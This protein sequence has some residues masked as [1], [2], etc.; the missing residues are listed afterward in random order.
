M[1]R[2]I[3]FLALFLGPFLV[4]L[5]PGAVS[6]QE[7]RVAY[8]TVTHRSEG[9]P[10]LVEIRLEPP[11]GGRE[12]AFEME[13]G[14]PRG[15]EGSW[16]RRRLHPVE[17][18]L[19]RLDYRFLEEGPW[20]FYVHYGSGLSGFQAGARLEVR[21][22]PGGVDRSS[23]AFRLFPEGVAQLPAYVQPLGYSG[24][25]LLVAV[26]LVAVGRILGRLKRQLAEAYPL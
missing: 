12:V 16:V 9:Q 15:G 7:E 5:M 4:W 13:R 21:Q 11:I 25:A 14:Q 26:L 22:V 18:G 23:A 19:Y 8:F 24:L 2:P 17:A 10:S 20:H 3:L 6:A 1:S